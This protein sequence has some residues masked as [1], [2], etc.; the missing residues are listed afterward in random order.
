MR[1][2]FEKEFPNRWKDK[3]T[4]DM[5]HNE[6]KGDEKNHHEKPFI[7]EVLSSILLLLRFRNGYCIP[8]NWLLTR[9]IFHFIFASLKN[10][11]IKKYTK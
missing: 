3:D 4:K 6:S 7:V 1:W 10:Q 11:L 8:Q 2:I 5:R 9:A